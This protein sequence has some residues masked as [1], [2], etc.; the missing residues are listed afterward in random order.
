M[1]VLSQLGG[2]HET[3]RNDSIDHV[4]LLN[5]ALHRGFLIHKLTGS[6]LALG[7]TDRGWH[8][9]KNKA[10]V[11]ALTT[12]EICTV[13]GDRFSLYGM[14]IVVNCLIATLLNPYFVPTIIV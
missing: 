4:N 1:I 3:Q 14:S 13:A 12:V 2:I 7:V 8:V 5:H 11:E 10:S 9:W 6:F